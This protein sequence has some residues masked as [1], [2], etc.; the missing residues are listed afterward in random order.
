MINLYTTV[1]WWRL[2]WNRIRVKSSLLRYCLKSHAT[3]Q[4]RLYY[5]FTDDLSSVYLNCSYLIGSSRRSRAWCNRWW[6][7]YREKLWSLHAYLWC[8]KF[9]P[10]HWTLL[11]WSEPEGGDV[12]PISSDWSKI[13]MCR[14][15]RYYRCRVCTFQ[16]DVVTIIF[17]MAFSAYPTSWGHFILRR[18][19]SFILVNDCKTGVCEF[20]VTCNA[21]VT[22]GVFTRVWRVFA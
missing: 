12:L 9:L 21:S 13:Q 2:R 1:N 6:P 15:G 11:L 4:G 22:L 5:K 16:T 3:L 18:V 20:T 7:L 14:K 8:E 17:I 10:K 19:L